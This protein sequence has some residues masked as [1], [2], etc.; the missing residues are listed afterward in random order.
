VP[1]AWSNTYAHRP[2]EEVVAELATFAER[3]AV[4]IDLSP[5]EDVHY[6]KALYRAMIPLMYVLVVLH[7]IAQSGI[8]SM[9][10]L[11]LAGTSGA[12][13]PFLVLSV[14]G[15]IGLVLSLWGKGDENPTPAD[16]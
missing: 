12:E 13:T 6:A 7:N 2:I 11:S 3:H 4:F 10:P 8:M 15:V 14:L 9:K 5:V 1:A 16:A